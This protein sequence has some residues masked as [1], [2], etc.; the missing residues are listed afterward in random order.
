MSSVTICVGN[1]AD[2]PDPGCREFS[3]GETP[4]PHRGF[5][6]RHGSDLVAYRNLCPH[7]RRPLNW[8]PDKFLDQDKRVILCSGHGAEFEIAT[9]KCMRG[10]CPGQSLAS[11]PV[12]VVG[13][14]IYVDT[15]E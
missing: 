1:L 8:H 12:N 14:V 10:P 5:L 11:L 13:G 7:A 3:W 9:G 15:A 4:V 6:V 2:L